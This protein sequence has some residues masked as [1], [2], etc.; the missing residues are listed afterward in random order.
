MAL[1]LEPIVHVIDSFEVSD[2]RARTFDL[3]CDTCALAMLL[4]LLHRHH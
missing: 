4:A 2:G 3:P 1:R